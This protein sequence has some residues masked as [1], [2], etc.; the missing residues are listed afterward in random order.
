MNERLITLI[1]SSIKTYWNHPAFS[2]YQGEDFTYADV[3]EKIVSLHILFCAAGVKKG[4][5]IALCGRNTSHWGISFFAI[6]TYGAVIV[7]I[8]HE[9]KPANIHHIVNHSESRL[10]LVGDIVW[11]GLD[12]SSMPRLEGIISVKDFSLLVGRNDL[13]QQSYEQLKRHFHEA[14]PDGLHPE[15]IHFEAEDPEGLAL[16][17]YT[18]GTT[19]ASKGVMIPYRGLTSNVRFGHDHIGLK[20]GDKHVCILPLAHTYGMSFDFLYE[21]TEGCHIIF[22]TK[23]PSP[24]IIFQAF[25]QYK[26]TLIVSVPLILEKVVRGHIMP[27]LHKPFNRFLLSLPGIRQ[28]ILRKAGKKLSQLF[29]DNFIEVIIGGAA[30]ND[31]VEH[32]LKEMN[33]RFTVGYGMTEC[34]P[35]ISYAHFDSFKLY[36]CG[37]PIERMEVRID[38]PSPTDTA[39]E[40]LVRGTNVFLGYY[41]NGQS[42]SEVIDENGWFHTGDLATMDKNGNISIKGRS[43]NMFLS[44]NGQNIYPEEVEDKL[45]N[46]PYV[47]E[48]LMVQRGNVFVGL[49][50]PDYETATRDHLHQDDLIRLMEESRKELNKHLPAYSQLTKI[51][52]QEEEFE[53]TPKRSIKRFLYQ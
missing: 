42:T 41:K 17:S 38:S 2:D 32:L 44:A 51:I 7:P 43:K 8:L 28:L 53:K 30:L 25:Q 47:S 52:L 4:D 49:V 18:S 11:S 16:I 22:L 20:P 24:R 31:E 23:V 19:S 12:E 26:P 3:A 5:K 39:G 35:L 21:F 37:R 33:F 50:Y 1:E 6:A 14:Y 27:Q 34:A 13:L 48:C 36:S 40:I 45:S 15:D 46:M 10:L 9:F 29:G